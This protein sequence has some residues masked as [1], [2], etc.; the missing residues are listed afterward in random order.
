MKKMRHLRK[1]LEAKKKLF[2]IKEIIDKKKVKGK[3]LYLIW[4]KGFS[5]DKRSWEPVENLLKE[6][7]KEFNTHHH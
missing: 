6:L 1:S 4:W 7:I 5:K 3:D 2:I